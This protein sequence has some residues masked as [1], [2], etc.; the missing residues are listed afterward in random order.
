MHMLPLD[1]A[2]EHRSQ[3]NRRWFLLP[4][5][6]VLVTLFA[7]GIVAMLPRSAPDSEQVLAVPLVPEL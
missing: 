3:F 5:G 1:S 2:L 4:I 7:F 6:V